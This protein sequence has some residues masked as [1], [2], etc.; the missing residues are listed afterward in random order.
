MS[1]TGYRV[2]NVGTAG[3]ANVVEPYKGQLILKSLVLDKYYWPPRRILV[4][5]PCLKCEGKKVRISDKGAWEDVSDL[6]TSGE[7]C[8]CGI[9]A[10]ID[11]LSL[12][13]K[14]ESVMW[15]WAIFGTVKLGGRVIPHAGSYRAEKAYV[16]ALYYIRAVTL[17]QT[18]ARLERKG[19]NPE[20]IEY[21]KKYYHM[22]GYPKRI[23]QIADLYEVPLLAIEDEEWGEEWCEGIQELL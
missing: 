10:V 6:F 21:C 11:P 13:N 17:E 15:S 12:K 5:Q 2:W 16:S 18:L 23:K 8:H 1:V 3:G 9:H 4:A 19:A 20:T 14:A 22:E 7:D